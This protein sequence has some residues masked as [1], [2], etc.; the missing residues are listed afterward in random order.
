MYKKHNFYSKN[1]KDTD[2]G[3]QKVVYFL[4]YFKIFEVMKP[5]LLK[6]H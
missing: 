6:L 2:P 1:E 4:C 5:F 3:I